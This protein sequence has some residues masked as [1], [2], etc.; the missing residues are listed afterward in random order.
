[1]MKASAG[2]ALSAAGHRSGAVSFRV[3]R[4]TAD[5]SEE[6]F[7]ISAMRRTPSFVN[8]ASLP[9]MGKGAYIADLVA[10]IGSIDVVLGEID[11]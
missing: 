2:H 9:L 8:L 3:S 10:M 5:G 6:R 7:P 4:P 1:M 11:R